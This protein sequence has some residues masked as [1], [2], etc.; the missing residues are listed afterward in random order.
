M[1]PRERPCCR[2]CPQCLL[3]RVFPGLEARASSLVRSTACAVGDP[4]WCSTWLLSRCFLWVTFPQRIPNTA[5]DPL[6]EMGRPLPDFNSRLS[7]LLCARELCNSVERLVPVNNFSVGT[8]RVCS[9]CS[10]IADCNHIVSVTT[11]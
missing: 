10:F 2:L 1:V 11:G 5:V 6:D 3:W 8:N 7:P 9:Y 4:A